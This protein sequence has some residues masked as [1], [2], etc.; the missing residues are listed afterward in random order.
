MTEG[1][2]TRGVKSAIQRGDQQEVKALRG[3][4]LLLLSMAAN[5]ELSDGE[6]DQAYEQMADMHGLGPV[7][8]AKRDGWRRAAGL[9]LVK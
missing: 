9:M 5:S 1:P 4:I 7:E 3:S 8:A 2:W 6:F